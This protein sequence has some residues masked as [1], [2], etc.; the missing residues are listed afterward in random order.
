MWF[1]YIGQVGEIV[2]QLELRQF[3]EVLFNKM[4]MYF[5]RSN[6][7]SI[8]DVHKKIQFLTPPV[9]MRPH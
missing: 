1:V 6:G 8:Y 4:Y 3:Q 9:H 2:K 5:M 7:S